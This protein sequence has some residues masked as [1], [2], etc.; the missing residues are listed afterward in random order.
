MLKRIIHYSLI[1]IIPVFFILVIDVLSGRIFGIDEIRESSRMFRSEA[2]TLYLSTKNLSPNIEHAYKYAAREDPRYQG[3]PEQPRLFR[4][5]DL[6]TVV[7]GNI[8]AEHDR[9]I[10]FLGGSTTECNEVDESYR[11]PKLVGDHLTDFTGIKHQGINLGVRGNTSHD[12]LNLLLNHPAAQSAK[13]VVL[14]HNINDRLM[15]SLRKSYDTFID[16]PAPTSWRDVTSAL[17]GTISGFWNYVS[18]RSNLLF[19]VN[20]ALGINP[21]TGERPTASTISE[22]S[23]EYAD[24]SLDK[25]LA[26][27]RVS[28]RSFVAVAR[29]MDK[30]PVL[31]TQ[32]IGRE[33]PLQSQFN[34]VIREISYETNVLLIDIDSHIRSSTHGLFLSD[35]IHLNNEGSR[36]ISKI[37]SS[38]I[39]KHIFDINIPH[40]NITVPEQAT[41]LKETL[42]SCRTPESF[43]S[44]V[45]VT[46]R[47]LLLRQTGRY[48][49][50]SKD[51]R[52]LIF[53]TMNG[54]KEAVGVFDVEKTITRIITDGD[55][56][57][58]DRHATFF[59]DAE[60]RKIVFARMNKGIEKLYQMRLSDDKITP[61]PLPHNLS[62]SI[63]AVHEGS[64]FFSGNKVG[65][66]GNHLG[67]PDLYRVGKSGDLQQLTN[68][69]WEE[70][71][72][73]IAPDGKNLFYI[74]NK[75]GQFEIGHLDI[76]TNES[77]T[78]FDTSA[79][80]W[81]PSV[82][83][84]G[85]WVTFA[86][87]SSGSWNLMLASY[88]APGQAIPLTDNDELDDWDPRFSPDGNAILFAS[89][90]RNAPPYMYIIC[91]FGE[92]EN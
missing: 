87:K 84:D 21:W 31:M 18:Y 75:K 33:S 8:V 30:T 25:S 43:D 82:S 63:P 12:S 70:W 57:E 67:A 71:R 54:R 7:G 39:A 10:L 78:F 26:H 22:E 37:I 83:P 90:N 45:T 81:D 49:V 89:S 74:S 58:G 3:D 53:Q 9:K 59:G 44:P 86:S 2:T 56:T 42:S 27:F 28:L 91:P 51:N 72:P 80:E 11:F 76:Q 34:Q 41:S 5:D 66:D 38:A 35:D 14:M 4:T 36:V 77:S 62:A 85:K 50:L 24:P 61:I 52:W 55:N 17:Q 20:D 65:S 47:Y 60:E 79:D 29:A 6:G 46:N 48:P 19:L 40:E 16:S 69:P 68:T 15:L 23:I 64:I 92:Y 88:E 13:T 32:A 73:A 1:V